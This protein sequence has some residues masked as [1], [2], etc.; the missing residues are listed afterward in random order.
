MTAASSAA[1]AEFPSR[2]VRVK[3]CGATRPE[4]AACCARLGADLLGLNFH[5]PS[6]R[7]VSPALARQLASAARAENPGIGI[8]GVFVEQG[9]AQ[10]DEIAD[11]AGLD[12]VQLHGDPDVALVERFADRAVRVVRV[13]ERLD[14]AALAGPDCWGVLLDA[15]HPDL[16]GGAGRTW[17]WASLGDVADSAARAAR[18]RGGSARRL[19]VAGGLR[20]DNVGRLLSLARPWGIDVASGVESAPGRKDPELMERLF[21]EIDRHGES[22]TAS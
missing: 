4:D 5:G 18:E 12:L 21:E 6:P 15:K 7:C 3:I 11:E 1:R 13:A 10:I 14:P 2:R 17:D 20:P 19:L 16:W 8:V 9:A 22:T